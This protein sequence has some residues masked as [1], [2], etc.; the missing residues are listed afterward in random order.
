MFRTD[1]ADVEQGSQ[2][3]HSPADFVPLCVI[4]FWPAILYWQRE[5]V[6]C[7]HTLLLIMTEIQ[8]LSPLFCDFF[9]K[10]VLTR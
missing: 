9:V 5:V 3:T 2:P 4:N 1:H 6:S 7:R 8:G 10:F